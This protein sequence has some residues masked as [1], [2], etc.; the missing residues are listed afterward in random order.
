VKTTAVVLAYCAVL[1]MGAVFGGFSL[2][3]LRGTTEQ[4]EEVISRSARLVIEVERLHETS[5]HLGM[6]VRSYLLTQDERFLVESR[7]KAQEF[8]DRLRDLAS[9]L[10]GSPA[11]QALAR[12]NELDS[13][14]TAEMEGL[15]AARGGMSEHEAVE[16]AERRAEPFREQIGVMLEELSRS[17]EADF[18]GAAHAAEVA[19]TKATQLLGALAAVAI[20][21]AIGLTVALARTLRLLG[22]G[23]VALEQSHARLER[24]NHDLDAF[25]GRIAHDLRNMISPLAL[26]ADMLEQGPPDASSVRSAA[27]RLQRIARNADGLIAS[28]LD[29]ARAGGQAPRAH[30]SARIAAVIHDVVEDVAA[31]ASAKQASIR[32]DADDVVVSCSRGL[33]QMVLMN[34]V[35]NALKYLEDERAH[36]VRL[37]ARTAGETC[38]I[39]VTDTGPGI[40]A[41]A[42]DRIFE[43][44]YRVPG[45]AAPGTGI[46]LA[47]VS[48]IVEAHHGRIS[49][50]SVLG[51][52][53]T[54]TVTL[55]LGEPA[56]VSGTYQV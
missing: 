3:K 46:G 17:E 34:L 25:A 9:Q 42:L 47:T 27:E 20:I 48:R 32:I 55:P 8:R 23:R 7:S 10:E 1:A 24:I 2:A 6:V 14:G 21:V 33:L 15:I 54:F 4:L 16:A 13:R 43:P 51:E 31:L 22:R 28:L 56:P 50:R 5:D 44:F 40:P 35:G 29:F 26:L 36:I 39:T 38:E 49:V 37:S 12:I 18:R 30:E 41:D 53:S 45:V 11:A 19:V 52:G